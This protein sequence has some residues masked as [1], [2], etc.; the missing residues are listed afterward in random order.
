[1]IINK[2]IN[3]NGIDNRRYGGKVRAKVGN[4]ISNCAIK[5]N[6]MKLINAE[7]VKILRASVIFHIYVRKKVVF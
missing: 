1:M 5:N 7:T 6:A 3:Y 2:N 4:K